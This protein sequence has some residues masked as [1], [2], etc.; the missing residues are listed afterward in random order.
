LQHF[1]QRLQ[2]LLLL[3]LLEQIWFLRGT[4]MDS[5]FGERDR[6]RRM[7]NEI[8]EKKSAF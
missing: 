3:L 7:K 8:C 2:L 5:C 6:I 4:R 1:W